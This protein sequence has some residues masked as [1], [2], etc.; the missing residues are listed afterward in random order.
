MTVKTAVAA[1]SLIA[2]A[3]FAG[4]PPA[5]D[6][7]VLDKGKA[8]FTINCVPCHGDKGDGTGPAA[9]ALNPKPRNYATE[10]FK[11]GDKLEDVFKTVT[12]GVPGTAMVAYGYLPEADRWALAYWVLELR[13]KGP[14]AAGAKDAGAAAPAPAPAAGAKDAGAAPAKKEPAKKK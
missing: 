10:P 11:Q 1:L 14:A 8:A 13:G 12:G 7:A 3:A 5:K 2:T 9:V 4:P 6:Q